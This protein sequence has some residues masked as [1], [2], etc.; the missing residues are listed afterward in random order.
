MCHCFRL[1]A[2][3]VPQD[4]A[5]EGG[6]PAERA[7]SA[8][9]GD[10]AAPTPVPQGPQLVIWGT[11]V[12]VSACKDKFRRFLE[13]FVDAVEEDERVENMDESEPLYMQKL[14]EVSRCTGPSQWSCRSR[15]TFLL[16]FFSVNVVIVCIFLCSV[17]YLLPLSLYF[18]SQRADL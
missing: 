3:L 13:T 11:D 8:A 16:F 18:W 9:A 1:T 12:V 10:G 2:P 7:P 15:L 17:V 5:S 14:R 6:E 4:A